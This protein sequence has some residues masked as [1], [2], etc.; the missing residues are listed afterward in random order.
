MRI[1][2]LTCLLLGSWSAF[3]LSEL[4]YEGTESLENAQIENDLIGKDIVESAMKEDPLTGSG[5]N[6][7]LHVEVPTIKEKEPTKISNIEKIELLALEGGEVTTGDIVNFKVVSKYEFDYLKKYKNK[8]IGE[9]LYV[10]EI[11]TENKNIFIRGILAE[12][13]KKKP[14]KVETEKPEYEFDLKNLNYKPSQNKKMMDFIIFKGP[15]IDLSERVREIGIPILITLFVILFVFLGSFYYL[16]RK[17]K[18]EAEAIRKA[19]LLIIKNAK[20]T[21]DFEAIYSSRSKIERDLDFDKKLYIKFLEAL[22]KVQYKK[23]W[24][25]KDSSEVLDLF[26]RFKESTRIKDGV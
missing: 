18:L 23:D 26:E 22:N 9:I 21:Q 6:E 7:D 15:K 16:R 3:S 12:P 5:M 19:T 11:T 25:L 10:L 13:E 17:N 24:E 8:R 2:I 1:V 20:T 14:L 4:E